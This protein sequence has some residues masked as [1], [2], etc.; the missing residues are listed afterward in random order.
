MKDTLTETKNT[1]QGINSR[2]DE[3]EKQINSLENKETENTQSEQQK[4]KRIQK[5][6]DRVRSLWDNFRHN[7]I[8]IMG[9][10][11]GGERE[12]TKN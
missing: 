2:A 11:E 1:L 8:L 5:N 7:H 3:A 4:E 10:P 9:V 6:E 12:S